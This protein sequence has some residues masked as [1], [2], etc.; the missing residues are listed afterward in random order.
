MTNC[1]SKNTPII[2]SYCG[3]RVSSSGPFKNCKLS[4]YIIMV[5]EAVRKIVQC[6]MHVNVK[7]T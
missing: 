6:N 2:S 4:D 1:S 7:F 5:I 3:Y